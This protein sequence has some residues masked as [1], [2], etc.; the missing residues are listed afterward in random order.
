MNIG[1]FFLASSLVFCC[2]WLTGCGTGTPDTSISITNSQN[3]TNDQNQTQNEGEANCTLNCTVGANG[4]ASGTRECEG[5]ATVVV[6]VTNLDVCDS[7]TEL[8]EAQATANET[9]EG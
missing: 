4:L 2:Y 8:V 9:T 7:V 3:Q 5:A 1:R 6:A